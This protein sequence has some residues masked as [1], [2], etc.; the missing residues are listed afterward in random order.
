MGK[1][2]VY[3]F[4]KGE[5]DAQ[6]SADPKNDLGANQRLID[7]ENRV[8]FNKVEEISEF[9]YEQHLQSI[10]YRKCWM[11]KKGYPIELT[12]L[13]DLQDPIRLTSELI[14]I[15]QS[16]DV[17]EAYMNAPIIRTG[18]L[19]GQ[20]VFKGYRLVDDPTFVP[21]VVP[22][23]V[24]KHQYGDKSFCTSNALPNSPFCSNHGGCANRVFGDEKSG[25][26]SLWG[27]LP[28]LGIGNLPFPGMSNGGCFQWGCGCLIPLLLLLLLLPFLLCLFKRDCNMLDKLT[29][30]DS[31]RDTVEVVKYDT[32]KV[33]E[34][35]TVTKIDT[36]R[37]TDTLEQ[38]E[39]IPDIIT[40]PNVNFETN[41][42]ILKE[43]SFK[44]LDQLAELMKRNPEMTIEIVGYTDSVGNDQKNQKLSED[45]AEAIKK[46]LVDKGVGDERIQAR[47]EGENDPI[48]DNRTEE[49]RMLNRRVEVT[50]KNKGKNVQKK[51]IRQ[52]NAK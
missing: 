33:V 6:F 39:S 41:K 16:N 27:I 48:G 14:A 29:H 7:L 35:E 37:M 20:A 51:E 45:R 28:R 34:K 2:V 15:R 18:R 43:G 24:C 52:E 38:T 50:V 25:C 23:T 17:P 42:A 8:V 49:G 31:L 4:Y 13:N 9:D 32:V 26:F 47:G 3:G 46:Y 44:S 40:L 21:P 10:E 22:P 5:I 11:V 36:L 19:N 1:K 30:R 12:F